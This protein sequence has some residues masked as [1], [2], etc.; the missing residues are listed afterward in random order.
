M[1][2]RVFSLFFTWP[3]GLSLSLTACE[4]FDEVRLPL[5]VFTALALFT[6][7]ANSTMFAWLHCGLPCIAVLSSFFV[8]SVLPFLPFLLFLPFLHV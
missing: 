4:V 8:N 6:H 3:R 7:F 5:P 1:K 2:E